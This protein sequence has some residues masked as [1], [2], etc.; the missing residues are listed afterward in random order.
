MGYRADIDGLRAIAV[1]AVVIYHAFPRLIPGG[2][3]G[4][5]IFFVIS[6]FLITGII[7][8]EIEA[9]RF[10]VE[11]F[12]ARRIR[13]I[14]PVLILVV[15]ATLAI[16]CVVLPMHEMQSLGSNIA[17]SAIF[18]QNFVLLG[19]VGY[20]DLAADKKPLLHLW[21]LGIEEQYY[22]VWPLTLLLI[23]RWRLNGLVVVL[24]LAV[25]SFVAGLVVGARAPDYAFY[26]PV[27]RAWELLVGSALMLWQNA[28]ILNSD[29]TAISEAV[30]AAAALAVIVSCWG[31]STSFVDPGWFTLLPVLGTAVL[32]GGGGTRVHRVLS[33][34]QVVFVGLISYP[35]YLWHFPLMAYARIAF[36]DGVPIRYMLAILIASVVLAWLTYR[37]VEFP[38]RFGKNRAG[39]KIAGL[40]TAMAA[41]GG[42]GLAA[43]ATGLPM[44]LPG[45]VRTFA[46]ADASNYLRL[47]TCL[48]DPDQ[49]FAAFSPACVGGGKRPL[50]LI[51]GDS[52]GAAFYAGLRMV[53]ERYG[54]DVAQFTASA[55]PPLVGFDRPE[56]P[57]CRSINDHV[58]RRVAELRPDVVILESKW[59]YSE[60]DLRGGLERTVSAVRPLTRKI[61]VMGP[62]AM[63]REPGLSANI[64]NYYFETGRVLPARTWYRSDSEGPLRSEA[65]LESEVATLGIDYISARR[66]LCNDAGCLARIGPNDSCLVNF[67]TDHLTV[68]GSTY[69]ARNS[70]EQILD[71][72]QA[73]KL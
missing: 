43:E 50:L 25:G 52:H 22:V 48:L 21:S 62:V 19:Q 31:Y 29:R 61:V 2:F 17:G 71:T 23:W 53:A 4:V 39:I 42:V 18:A 8:R 49:N 64:L 63:W 14:F 30:S 37:L 72:K 26:L 44:R 59:D 69:L 12:Y 32:L 6:G 73:G 10:S 1:V 24:A 7:Q 67:D 60:S 58:L 70:I 28:H 3:F 38:L 15:T 68:A 54:A 46:Y 66:I 5:D 51:W 9:N 11:N 40:V 20:F 33:I 27:T 35:L 47:R 41:M 16:G 57:F 34:P 13:R 55:C 45:A 56:R 36:V 65:I